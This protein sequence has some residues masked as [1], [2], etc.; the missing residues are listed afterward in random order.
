MPG[1]LWWKA[2]TVYQIYPRSFQDANGDGVGDL[3]GIT[4][5]LDYLAWL[6]VDALWL[7]PVCRSPMADYGYDVSDYCDIDPLFGTLADFD[8]LVAEAHRR[9]LRVIMDF[10]PNHTSIAHPWFRESRASRDNARR[11]WYIWRDPK[12]DG[13]PPNNW[14]GN[15][16]GPAWTL[17]PAT[18]QSYYHAFLKEQ[19]DLN[20]RNPEVRRA[21]LDVLRFWLDRGVD[22]FRVDVIWHLIKDAALRDN[23]P[24]PDY[25]PGDAEINSLTPLYSADQPE[26]MEVVAEMRAVLDGYDERVL[27]GEIYLPLERLMAYY[28]VDLS[29]AHLPF[30]FQLIQARWHAET[31]AALVAEYEAALPEGGWPNWVLGNHDQP[32]IAARVGAAQARVA[33]VLLLTLRGTPTLYYGDEI[34]LARV[35]IPP[36][37]ARDPWERNEPGRGRDPARTP[38]QWD[39]TPRAG[40]SS[41]EPWLPLDPGAATC[42]VEVLRDDPGSILTLYRRLLA[43]RREHAALSLGLYRAVFVA[44][45]VLV[46]ERAHGDEVLRILLNFG[47]APCTVPLPPDHAWRVLLSSSGS[48]IAER[49]ADGHLALAGDEALVL[50]REPLSPENV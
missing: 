17:D 9:R 4:A 42:N 18:G 16:G 22:G 13:A 50:L 23:P 44:R 39:R 48:R 2:G 32:R 19:P 49:P 38:M 43:L 47:H 27:I 14:V 24:N 45:D 1:E 25:V 33:A 40:F 20:W 11:D 29:G 35:P 12:P 30:N 34:G 37:R 7:S 5:R 21:M 15:F 46:Y 3:K 10:V 31:I 8:A 28:G 41:A 36:G 6:G 26:V